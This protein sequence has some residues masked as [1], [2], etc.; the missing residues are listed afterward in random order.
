MVTA[1]VACYDP[2]TRVL[3]WSRAGHPPPLVCAADGTTRFL[4]DVNAT[5]LG[6]MGK[7][8]ASARVDLTE[9][10]LLVLYTDGLIERRDHLIDEGLAWLAERTSALCREPAQNI[11][12][13]LVDHSFSSSPSADDI[14]VLVLRVALREP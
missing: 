13:M 5:P 2:S 9:G 11:C 1:V 6:T 8:F 14:C 7:N 12:R 3:T 10:S 4:V